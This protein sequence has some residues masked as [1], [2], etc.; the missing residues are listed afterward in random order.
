MTKFKKISTIGVML[1]VIGATSITAFAASKYNSP[2][3]AAAGLT[4][5]TVESV[6]A[7]RTETGNSYGAIASEAGKL[8]EFKNE[9]LEIKKDALAEKVAAGKLTQ[10]EADKIIAA[11]EENQATCDGT[12]SARIGQKMGAGFGGGNCNGQGN[13]QGRSQGGAGRGQGSCTG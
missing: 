13:G 11:I 7:E 3:E 12:G 9:M 4:G 5:K 1:L 2:A 8:E 10:E 6:I